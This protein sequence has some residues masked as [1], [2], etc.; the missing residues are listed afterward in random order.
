MLPTPDPSHQLLAQQLFLS[1]GAHVGPGEQ[2]RLLFAP[3]DVVIDDESVLQPDVLLL[4]EGTRPARRPWVIPPPIWVAEVMSPET[5]RRDRN[6]KLTLYA[7]HGVEEAWIVDPDRECVVVHD[8]R[9]GTDE[10]CT[11][12]AE[13]R[14][15]EGFRLEVEP[16]FAILRG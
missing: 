9:A 16:Y 4:P 5:D 2:R 12:V 14:V 7:R 15:I 10:V 6:V 11:E 13:S 1:L 3:V 8:L